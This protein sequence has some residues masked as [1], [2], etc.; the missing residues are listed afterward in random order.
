[1]FIKFSDV[2]KHLTGIKAQLK[3]ELKAL[4][5]MIVDA[6][7]EKD[8]PV[9]VSKYRIKSPE[10]IYLKTKRKRI[11]D[12]T[13]ITDYAG[14]RVLT[15]FEKD[16]FELN[17]FLLENYKNRGYELESLNVFNYHN[18]EHHL[19]SITQIAAKYFPEVPVT[20]IKKKSGYKSIHYIIKR[21]LGKAQLLIEIQLRTLLQDVWGELEHSLSYKKGDIH[22]HIKKSFAILS[23]DLENNDML[24]SHLREIS[25]R[26][27]S[28]E[29]F[30]NEK[31]GPRVYLNYEG[32]IVPEIFKEDIATDFQEYE[33]IMLNVK[34]F[35][36]PAE[37][38]SLCQQQKRHIKKFLEKLR[39]VS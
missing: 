39:Q 9:Y 15:L 22:P 10:S 35:R 29:K 6:R 36:D 30:S 32:D 4:D 8:I 26:E 25:D 2:E 34:S 31:S 38:K 16:L 14:L 12:L 23:R 13:T 1:M 17:D 18:D 5:E 27:R 21:T 24:I 3:G 20:S 11:T 19:E 37:K 28:G 33:N 7:D